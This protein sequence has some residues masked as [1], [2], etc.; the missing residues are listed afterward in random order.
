MRSLADDDEKTWAPT[1]N[2]ARSFNAGVVDA[3]FPVSR[4][5]LKLIIFCVLA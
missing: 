2:G 4:E 5:V 3:D 1:R